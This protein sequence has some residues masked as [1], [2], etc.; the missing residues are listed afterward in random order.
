MY[1]VH[2]KSNCN[3]KITSWHFFNKDWLHDRQISYNWQDMKTNKT[4]TARILN[5]ARR[6]F[7]SKLQKVS[8]WWFANCNEETFYW[9]AI[10]RCMRSTWFC[11]LVHS[12]WV[13]VVVIVVYWHCVRVVVNNCGRTLCLNL[14]HLII[15]RVLIF[16]LSSVSCL[17]SAIIICS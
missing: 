13:D 17:C 16:L 14:V 1:K 9:V 8:D 5:L 4:L 7:L 3:L 15:I 2:F 12:L 10:K 11:P 6:W